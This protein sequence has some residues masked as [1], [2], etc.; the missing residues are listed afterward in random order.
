MIFDI[1][2]GKNFRRKARFVADGHKTNTP[3]AM[4]YLSVLSRK[5]VPT[6]LKIA[7]LNYLDVLAYD[8]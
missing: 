6:A 3:A 2:I 8:I 4:T 1:K 7:T 5:S